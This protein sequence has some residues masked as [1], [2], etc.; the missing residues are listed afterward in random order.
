MGKVPGMILGPRPTTK[1]DFPL[2]TVK[3]GIVT[4]ACHL[5]TKLTVVS[6][7]VTFKA[8][9]FATF[10]SSFLTDPYCHTF[11]KQGAEPPILSRAG[12]ECYNSEAT[13]CEL[14]RFQ[15]LHLL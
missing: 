1:I 9:S 14:G 7:K 5:H 13:S 15:N 3:Y 4:F 12:V 2:V 10:I 6:L 8:D 11:Q